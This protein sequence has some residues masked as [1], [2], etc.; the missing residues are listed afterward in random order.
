[1]APRRRG[2]DRPLL[3]TMLDL[4]VV[5]VVFV[6]PVLIVTS[7]AAVVVEHLGRMVGV[8]RSDD[9]IDVASS[10]APSEE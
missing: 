9:V 4:G 2:R 3:D 5:G 10:E 1:M 8:G 7:S 6:V